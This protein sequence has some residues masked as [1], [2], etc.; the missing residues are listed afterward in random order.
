MIK[1]KYCDKESVTY[2]MYLNIELCKAHTEI[3]DNIRFDLDFKRQ[4]KLNKEL[5]EE[6]ET[7]IG[8][9]K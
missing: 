6:F 8:V 4:D 1:C 5:L 9:K 7:K 2:V 3:F